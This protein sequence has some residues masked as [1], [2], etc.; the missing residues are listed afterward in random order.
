MCSS[1]F[2]WIPQQISNFNKLNL[3]KNNQIFHAGT[4][5]DNGKIFAIGG[6]V[7]NFISMSD[8]FYKARENIYKNLEKLNWDKG[9]YRKDI[10]YKVIEKWELSQEILEERKS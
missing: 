2:K 4:K 7:L 6:R 10:G 5:K 9:F 3:E 1:L 8:N